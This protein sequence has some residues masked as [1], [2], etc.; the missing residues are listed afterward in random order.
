MIPTM[1]DLVVAIEFCVIINKIAVCIFPTYT[2]SFQAKYKDN[3][4]KSKHKYSKLVVEI[5]RTS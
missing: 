4:P 2:H 1:Q 3:K 5:K